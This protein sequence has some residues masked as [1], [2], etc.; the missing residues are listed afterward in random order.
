MKI[1]FVA[2]SMIDNS[3]GDT[4]IGVYKRCLR[5]GFEMQ[6]RGHE[7]WVHC[8][9][10]PKF[11][12]PLVESAL[13]SFKYLDVP[14][15]IQFVQSPR[16]R[17]RYL[18]K[19][20]AREQFDM[21][22]IGEVPIRGALLDA[23]LVAS[24][25]KIPLVLLDN[26]YRPLLAR[27]FVR[28]HGNLF[29]G[30]VLT[31]LSSFHPRNM[32]AFYCAAPPFLRGE[33]DAALPLLCELQLQGTRFVTVLGYERKAAVLAVNLLKDGVDP[34]S[35]FLF[36]VRDPEILQEHLKTLSP[37]LQARCRV[38]ASPT[39]NILF[40]LLKHSRL[41][42]GKCGFMQASEAL[43]LGTPFLGIYYRGCFSTITLP[44]EAQ[45]YVH[46]TGH[47]NA[48]ASTR[49]AFERLLRVEPSALGGLHEGGLD[50]LER[51]ASFLESMPL[52]QRPGVMKESARLG[53][54][55]PSVTR[56]LRKKHHRKEI[57]VESVRATR[58]H[59]APMGR[60]DYVAVHYRCAG[61]PRFA[62]LLGRRYW[63]PISG[64]FLLRRALRAIP[65]SAILYRS[66]T[67]RY[68]LEEDSGERS[69]PPV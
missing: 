64:P 12:D 18:R 53:Y 31:G 25:L 10:C 39:E 23:T 50:G 6:A 56:A 47:V 41:V 11:R 14:G 63:A 58:V 22:V 46:S 30:I 29:D 54:T 7:I 2:Y 9:G 67:L 35:H 55:V 15:G 21:V 38:I 13:R 4:L 17:R 52:T 42:I 24:E 16:V 44:F 66:W 33:A 59:D 26:A 43:A 27:N 65:K 20:F 40:S 19:Y 51:V 8:V 45:R 60:F 57:V 49:R 3:N 68:S 37:E 28:R 5:I 69:L 48:D 62:I 36:L 61:V 32:G 34:D 1:L